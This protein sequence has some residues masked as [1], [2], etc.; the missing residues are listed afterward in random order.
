MRMHVRGASDKAFFPPSPPPPCTAPPSGCEAD[1]AAR[2][3]GVKKLPIVRCFEEDPDAPPPLPPGLLSASL[4]FRIFSG[5]Q[6][7]LKK[8]FDSL[9]GEEQGQRTAVR[10]KRR[11]NTPRMCTLIY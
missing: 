4:R 5:S 7:V 3:L 6:F 2:L 8:D 9:G 1:A 11:R 10:Q